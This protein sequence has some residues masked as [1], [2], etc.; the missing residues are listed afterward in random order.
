[1][2]VVPVSRR[3]ERR[4]RRYERRED[5][6][7]RR[8]D[9]VQSRSTWLMYSGKEDTEV[10][11]V[12]IAADTVVEAIDQIP[13]TKNGYIQPIKVRIQSLAF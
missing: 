11:V 12:G 13:R 8:Q 3:D 2:L 5:R 7:Q 10:E 4:F 9:R 1:M 6:Y